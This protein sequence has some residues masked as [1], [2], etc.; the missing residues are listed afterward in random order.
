MESGPVAYITMWTDSLERIRYFNKLNFIILLSEY[1]QRQLS[2]YPTRTY[3]RT[4]KTDE[5]TV[6]F[7]NEFIAKKVIVQL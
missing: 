5:D 3:G 4:E 2:I 7:L 1:Y 6:Q